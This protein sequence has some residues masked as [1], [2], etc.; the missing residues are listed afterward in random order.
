MRYV[1]AA[2][3]LVWSFGAKGDLASPSEDYGL[4]VLDFELNDLTLTPRRPAELER[5]AAIAPLLR[6]TL[7]DK[8][9]YR[10]VEVAAGQQRLADKS[11]GYLFDHPEEAAEL[12]RAAHARWIIVGR[13]HKPT[14]LFVYFR[15]HL[16]DATRSAQVADLVVEVKGPQQKLTAR[17]VEALA[18]RIDEAIQRVD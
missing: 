15:A 14:E 18:G 10:L 2:L 4:V 3:L 17:G 9:D 6:K 7:Q 11:I 13:V 16:I 12:A 8:Y 5:T 1:L